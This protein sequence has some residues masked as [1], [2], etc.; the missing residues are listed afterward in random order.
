M[1]AEMNRL[2]NSKNVLHVCHGDYT[3]ARISATTSRT[4]NYFFDGSRINDTITGI[5]RS[6]CTD[7]LFV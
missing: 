2:G 1:A 5:P 4:R 6:E 3:D 7:F